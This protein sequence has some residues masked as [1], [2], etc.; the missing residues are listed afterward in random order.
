MFI[1]RSLRWSE[2]QMLGALKAGTISFHLWGS[3]SWQYLGIT[4]GSFESIQIPGSLP[5][6][7][8]LESLQVWPRHRLFL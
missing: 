4:W 7:I 1:L 5:Q 3:Q 8:Q 6:T 2:N